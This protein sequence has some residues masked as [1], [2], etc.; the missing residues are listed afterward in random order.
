[1]QRSDLRLRLM[2]E[3]VFE[4]HREGVRQVAEVQ[5]VHDT[6]RSART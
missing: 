3:H 2:P 4:V 1:M 5:M 6:D